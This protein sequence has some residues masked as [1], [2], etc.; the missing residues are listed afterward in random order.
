MVKTYILGAT[1]FY[2]FSLILFLDYTVF[3]YGGLSA[4]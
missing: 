2:S 1:I 3:W 4:L